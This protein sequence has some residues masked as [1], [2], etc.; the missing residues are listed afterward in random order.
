MCVCACARV[1][2]SCVHTGRWDKEETDKLKA[3]V[4]KQLAIRSQLRRED[5]E[6]EVCVCVCV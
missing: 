2:G 1:C 5:L 3:A 6:E 4:E